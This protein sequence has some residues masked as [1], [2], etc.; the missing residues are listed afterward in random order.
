MEAGGSEIWTDNYT[1]FVKEAAL[2]IAGVLKS[3]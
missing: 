2:S 3:P 1:A